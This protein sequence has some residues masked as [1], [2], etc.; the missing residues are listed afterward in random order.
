MSK[1][2]QHVIRL[3][4]DPDPT[5]QS[6]ILTFLGQFN[7]DISENLANEAIALSTKEQNIL[8]RHL[9]QGR[10]KTLTHNWQI[11]ARFHQK[12][13]WE[14]FEY[15]LSLLSDYLHDGLTLRPS[16]TDSLDQL[17]D[18]V[19]LGNASSSA[20][21]IGEYLFKT[22][23]F[24]GN[25]NRYFAIE[26]SDLNWV[27]HNNL[28]NPIS[29]VIIYMLIANRFGL[30]VEGCNYPGHF[31][32]WISDAEE[33]ILLDAYNAA[34]PIH[35]KEVILDNPSISDTAKVALSGPC[36]LN[37]IIQRV[38]NNIQT[39][40]SKEGLTSEID[41]ILRLKKSLHPAPS[42]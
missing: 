16:L 7:G 6:A 31:L 41:L 5:V 13:D 9:I 15:L 27:I 22:G 18:E 29:L 34:R 23:R 8:S 20:E 3:L 1:D 42:I 30:L 14:S 38:L 4:D 2:L 36:S 33:P 10:Q 26:N 19:Q 24:Q 40:L 12:N 39:S 21:D 28:G 25:K 37:T 32:A 17:A 11:P 35:P